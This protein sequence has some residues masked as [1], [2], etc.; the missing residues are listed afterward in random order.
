MDEKTPVGHLSDTSEFKDTVPLILPGNSIKKTDT[1]IINGKRKGRLGGQQ[2]YN[3]INGM[4][5]ISNEDLEV[6]NPLQDIGMG[7][8][9]ERTN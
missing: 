5:K 6:N 9:R 4:V 3:R 2:E 7:P 1:D 8:R